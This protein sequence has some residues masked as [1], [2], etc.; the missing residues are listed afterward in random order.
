MLPT[1]WSLAA[2]ML[3]HALTVKQATQLI[4]SI[5]SDRL[6]LRARHRTTASK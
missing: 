3:E 6:H 5:N 2:S 1:C 4:A